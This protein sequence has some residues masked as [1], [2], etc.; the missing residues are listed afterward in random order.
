MSRWYV[1]NTQ[2]RAEERA[3]FHLESQGFEVF[4]PRY[5]KQRRHAR[6]TDIVLRP[7][8]PSYLFVRLDVTHQQW[9]S[10]NGTIGVNALMASGLIPLPVPRGLVEGLIANSDGKS[11]IVVSPPTLKKGQRVTID[12]GAFADYTAVFEEMIDEKRVLLLLDL[13]GQEVRL[14]VP[15]GALSA[16]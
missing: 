11:M 10:I 7:L 16:A 3:A 12:T 4:L 6:R 2:T 5:R 14:Q 8:F 15:V 13:L 1:I 9:R